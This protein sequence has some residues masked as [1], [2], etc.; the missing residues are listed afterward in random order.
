MNYSKK[1]KSKLDDL[2]INASL[3]PNFFKNPDS[4]FT[5]TRKLTFTSVFHSILTMG[6]NSLDYELLELFNFNNST[7]SSSAFVQARDKILISAFSEVFSLFSG[8]LNN[9]RLF[10][11]FRLLA[12]DGTNLNIFRNPKDIDSFV[13]NKAHHGYNSLNLSAIYDLLN[14]VY[15][16]AVIQP[17][18]HN[19]ER[20]ALI[21]MLPNVDSKSIII[22]DRGY[23]SY[24]LFAHIENIN[25]KYVF[26]VKDINSNGILSGFNFPNEEF[27]KEITVNISNFQRKSLKSLPNFKFSPQISRFDFSNTLNPVYT[28]TFRV[29]RIKLESGKYESIITNLSYDFSSCDIKELYH[30]RWGIETSFRHLKYAV[31]LANFHSKKRDSISQEI[32][33]RLILHNFCEAI[34]Q[35]TVLHRVSTKHN[36]IINFARAV[37]ICRKY[38]KTIDA[39]PFNVEALISK[40]LSIVR[41]DRSFKR[42]I[43]TKRFTSFVYRVA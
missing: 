42:F 43:K 41:K 34:I 2:I 4:D 19:D 24:N 12:V 30:L 9:H 25:S 15:T 27:D 31:G 22:A 38:L 23:E 10:R 36:Y 26:R 6:G 1:L 39:I 20:G 33:A 14:H 21:E 8:S 17:A 32:Y 5:R 35:N 18:N 7:P 13:A 40:Y 16:D 28:L 3:N 37:Q 11:G 29:V